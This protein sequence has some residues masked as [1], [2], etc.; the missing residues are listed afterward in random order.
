MQ[1][2]GHFNFAARVII[3]GRSFLSYL[4]CLA[5]SVRELHW[6]IRLTKAARI[7][8]SMWREFLQNW[9]GQSLFLEYL[10][11]TNFDLRLYTDAAG[12]H[13]YG[14]IFG[15]KWFSSSWTPEFHRFLSGTRSSSLIELIPIVTAAL[16]WGA[17]WTRRRIIFYCDNEALVYILNKRTFR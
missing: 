3:P 10:P 12:G 8:L 6:H 17:E 5:Y 11:V 9:N 4:F 13:G 15:S 1:L 7:D 14:G 2:I 16:L